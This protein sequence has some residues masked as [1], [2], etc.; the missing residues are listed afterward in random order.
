MYFAP[1]VA[2]QAQK[3][4][5]AWAA[6]GDDETEQQTNGRNGSDDDKKHGVDQV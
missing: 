2:V 1:L 4:G 5:R 6:F 3:I